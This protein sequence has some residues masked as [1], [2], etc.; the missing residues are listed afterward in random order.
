MT[1][2]KHKVVPYLFFQTFLFAASPHH[3]RVSFRQCLCSVRVW[4]ISHSFSIL[5]TV[6]KKVIFK[7]PFHFAAH[8]LFSFFNG[9]A[10]LN[11]LLEISK[12]KLI[13]RLLIHHRLS[14]R[15]LEISKISPLK[16]E[17]MSLFFLHVRTYPN[18]KPT[19][20]FF[21]KSYSTQARFLSSKIFL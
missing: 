8:I 11:S 3:G 12:I 6:C 9:L 4:I 20:T 17:T 7:Q 13:A 16:S 2:N 18:I 19:N 21:K 10:D 15:E 5:F 14:T 1:W